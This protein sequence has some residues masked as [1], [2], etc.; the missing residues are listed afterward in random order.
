MK[1]GILG[2]GGVAQTLARRCSAAGHQVTFGSREPSAKRN[3]DSSVVSLSTAVADHDAVVNATPGSA[4][5]EMVEGVRAAAFAAKVLIDVANANTPSFDLVYPNDSLA[6][7]LQVALP[8]T[9][10][11]KTMNHRG[12]ADHDGAGHPPA[13]QRLPLRR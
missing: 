1:I 3:M 6:E 7:K 12:D 8:D 11:V 5:L 2:T 13:E 9:H 4:S 10:V